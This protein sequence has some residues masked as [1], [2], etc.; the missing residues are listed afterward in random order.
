L[1]NAQPAFSARRVQ[2]VTLATRHRVPT[3]Y[4]SRNF[5]EIGGLMS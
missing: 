5:I 4:F 1:V 2:F 3:I